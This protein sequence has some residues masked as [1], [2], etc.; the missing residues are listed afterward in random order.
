MFFFLCE[1]FPYSH[2]W[3]F[4]IEQILTFSFK[5]GPS[6]DYCHWIAQT[7]AVFRRKVEN[8]GFLVDRVRVGDIVW[9]WPSRKINCVKF[10]PLTVHNTFFRK[11]LSHLFWVVQL[12]HI[13]GQ[14][15]F[16]LASILSLI[17]DVDTKSGGWYENL[18]DIKIVFGKNEKLETWKYF[19][20]AKPFQRAEEWDCRWE[21]QFIKKNLF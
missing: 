12:V 18:T 13:I 5:S 14:V 7:R 9:A 19:F 4:K 6:Y 16:D 11:I 10:F 3:H 20:S 2:H 15:V 1:V 21:K 8:R 17:N